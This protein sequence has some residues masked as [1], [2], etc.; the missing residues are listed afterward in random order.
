MHYK[1][2]TK[3]FPYFFFTFKQSDFSYFFTVIIINSTN[4]SFSHYKTWLFFMENS[5]CNEEIIFSKVLGTPNSFFVVIS[6]LLLSAEPC[7]EH[8]VRAGMRCYLFGSAAGREL[9][10]KIA[11]KLCKKHGAMLAELES[12]EESQDVISYIQKTDY[13]RGKL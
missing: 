6:Y 12:I 7:P 5:K 3:D 4:I 8:F 2:S 11:S 10:W 9:D 1:F 13:L